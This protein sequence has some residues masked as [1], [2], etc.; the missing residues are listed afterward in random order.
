MYKSDTKIEV[1]NPSDLRPSTPLGQQMA[2]L[3][4]FASNG[5]ANDP[6]DRK[7]KPAHVLNNVFAPGSQVKADGGKGTL[8]FFRGYSLGALVSCAAAAMVFPWTVPLIALGTTAA[9]VVEGIRHAYKK[10][11]KIINARV[12]EAQNTVDK[13]IETLDHATK[14]HAQERTQQSKDQL[15]EAMQGLCSIFSDE[16][17][18]K[19]IVFNGQRF[20][21]SK[22][23]FDGSTMIAKI[24]KALEISIKEI[25]IPHVTKGRGP[26]AEPGREIAH[27]LDPRVKDTPNISGPSKETTSPEITPQNNL[28]RDKGFDPR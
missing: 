5:F 28:G 14:Q 19:P 13:M 4:R 10:D 7:L 12:P 26:T 18:Y 20:R 23:A 27:N 6:L 21:L 2:S 25:E 3:A 11:F 8:K 24:N 16:I 15:E 9:V 22:S 17:G 1:H